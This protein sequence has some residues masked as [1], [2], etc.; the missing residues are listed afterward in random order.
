MLRYVISLFFVGIAYFGI[1]DSPQLWNL[2]C[3]VLILLVGVPHGAADHRINSTIHKNANVYKFVLRYILIST[4][5]ILWW[6][7]LPGKA[8]IFF[9][10]LSAY[11]FGQEFLEDFSSNYYKVW[12]IMI[13]GSILL[14]VPMLIAYPEIKPS[15]ELVAKTTLPSIS[16]V[17][18]YSFILILLTGGI[19]H[20]IQLKNKGLLDLKGLY[21]IGLKLSILLASFVVLPFLIAF[22]L[23]FILF[24]SINAFK[25]QFQ[26][27]KKNIA[28]YSL[29][30]FIKDLSLFSIASI[31]GM[32]ALLFF[33][34]TNNQ[35]EMVQYFF[36]LISIVTLPHSILFDQFYKNRRI[37]ST[38]DV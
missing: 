21:T 5:Y 20:L 35:Q 1:S 36:I 19:L 14:F 34:E 16:P 3:L 15:I 12:E 23:Y 13:W 18:K 29:R 8:L 32:V 27:L 17:L 11:H 37:A 26:W 33:V 7:L 10:I 6:I 2:S 9:L 25:H 28:N 30:S 24:H 22:T 38:P 4:G 31:S